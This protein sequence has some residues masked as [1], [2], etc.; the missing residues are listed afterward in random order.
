MELK[1]QFLTV[2]K[3]KSAKFSTKHSGAIIIV[4]CGVRTIYPFEPLQCFPLE[5]EEGCE[6]ALVVWHVV[7]HEE[8]V[9]L[10]D[11]G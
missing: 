10:I 1:Q 9:G 7:E 4:W 5:V 8:L 11:P 6:D 3:L 2:I